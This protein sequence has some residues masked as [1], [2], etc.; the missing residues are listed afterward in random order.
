VPLTISLTD[1]DVAQLRTTTKALHGSAPGIAFPGIE[2]NV[3]AVNFLSFRSERSRGFVRAIRVS[4][5]D[6]KIEDFLRERVQKA[7]LHVSFSAK[8]K[9]V[10]AACVVPAP[11]VGVIFNAPLVAEDRLQPADAQLAAGTLGFITY[12]QYAEQSQELQ[13]LKESE[14]SFGPLDE[15][16]KEDFRGAGTGPLNSMGGLGALFH[17]ADLQT[18][19]STL[20][21]GPE[22]TAFEERL[23]K[24]E[25]RLKLL[26]KLHEAYQKEY[27]GEFIRLYGE[28]SKS[29]YVEYKEKSIRGDVT[30]KEILQ[31]EFPRLALPDRIIIVRDAGKAMILV[32]APA[33]FVRRLSQVTAR[34]EL[35]GA[36][37][38]DSLD[39]IYKDKSPRQKE[40]LDEIIRR[41]SE[42]TPEG[43]TKLSKVFRDK[44][45]ILLDASASDSMDFRMNADWHR[46]IFCIARSVDAE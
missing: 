45:M 40:A 6:E 37:E 8:D 18:K 22:K 25:M 32:K 15:K 19:I 31:R 21:S 39:V 7:V 28:K 46:G 13:A 1:S 35:G 30:A 26:D 23:N 43:R 42:L 34:F 24:L 36:S 14:A 27:G 20:P 16:Y 29:R 38:V 9:S 10:L 33:H 44:E 12:E 41:W 3:A 17:R 11:H 2:A 4:F 5:D